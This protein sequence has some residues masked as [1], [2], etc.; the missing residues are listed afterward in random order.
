MRCAKC[1]GMIHIDE[2]CEDCGVD[3]RE[4]LEGI[5]HDEM[6]NLFKK[7]KELESEHKSIDLEAS[8]MACELE[9]SSLILPASF[10][11]D[12]TGFVQL[13]GPKNKQYIA[14]CTD[15]D[16]FRKCFDELTP[17]TNSWKRQLKLLE[18]GAEGFVINPMGEVCFLEME[19]IK[20]YFLDDE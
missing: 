13:P 11:E 3:Y 18:C 12:C 9:N 4:M 8:L 6:R 16:E 2:K 5:S 14:L 1:G 19:F 17:L 20:R 7:I 15:M 10:E